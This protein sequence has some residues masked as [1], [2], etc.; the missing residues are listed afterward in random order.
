M[1]KRFNEF[2][3]EMRT[4]PLTKKEKGKWFLRTPRQIPGPPGGHPVPPGYKRVHDVISGGTKLVKVEEGIATAIRKVA[5]VV[6]K[7]TTAHLPKTPEVARLTA[8]RAKEIEDL[9][10]AG[11]AGGTVVGGAVAAKKVKEKM[12]EGVGGALLGGLAGGLAGGPI[13]AA[14]GAYAGHKITQKTAQNQSFLDAA[15]AN[16]AADILDKRRA[17]KAAA[18]GQSRFRPG[19]ASRFLRNVAVRKSGGM[20]AT[21]PDATE[22]VGGLVKPKPKAAAP[23]QRPSNVVPLRPRQTPQ[24]VQQAAAPNEPV[25]SVHPVHVNHPAHGIFTQRSDE[26]EAGQQLAAK[27]RAGQAA[28]AAAIRAAERQKITKVSSNFDAP[29]TRQKKEPKPTSST[30]LVPEE[31]GK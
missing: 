26:T 12:Q 31:K 29:G 20:Y 10:R 23:Q 28:V 2:I 3:A 8:K 25:T 27:R 6:A 19:V 7:D 14:I 16:K 4:R 21:S 15:I 18:A 11:V 1:P 30:I 22:P 13:G 5:T 17:K 9:G 24:Q